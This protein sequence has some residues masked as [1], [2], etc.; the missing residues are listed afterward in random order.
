MPDKNAT[1]LMPDWLER[2]AQLSPD[3]TALTYEGE[4]WTFAD[5]NRRA[6]KFAQRLSRFVDPGDRVATL[7][8]NGTAYVLAVHA[9]P[10][11]GRI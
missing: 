6:E 1:D 11:T 7:L 3:K 2:R 5:L 4:R 10:R 8:G 9:V